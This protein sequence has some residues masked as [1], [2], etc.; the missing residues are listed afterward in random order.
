M[1]SAL[2][3]SSEGGSQ[4]DFGH[5][6]APDLKQTPDHK[7]TSDLK[8]TPDSGAT[9]GSY[10]LWTVSPILPP[11]Q[12]IPFVHP[13]YPPSESPHQQICI[14]PFPNQ[15]VPNQIIPNQIIP[16]QIIPKQMTTGNHEHLVGDAISVKSDK[17][18]ELGKTPDPQ[19]AHHKTARCESTRT[20]STSDCHS[21]SAIPNSVSDRT[22]HEIGHGTDDGTE[23]SIK[24][25]FDEERDYGREWS[26]SES[27]STENTTP[28]PVSSPELKS[29][30]ELRSSPDLTSGSSR[31]SSFSDASTPVLYSNL[32]PALHP[33]TSFQA[34]ESN[35]KSRTCKSL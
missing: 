17:S 6:T 7:Q 30:P 2:V 14:F 33:C 9:P 31:R 10:P 11:C 12:F 13:F 21:N 24:S 15:T 27:L 3:S 19:K 20:P 32:T 16:S 35:S 34:D 8:Q 28:S 25:E 26:N 4:S 22:D 18:V 5:Q 23:H 1:Q 29:S